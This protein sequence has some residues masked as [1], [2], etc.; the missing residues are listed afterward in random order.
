M[1]ILHDGGQPYASTVFDDAWVEA[2]VGVSPDTLAARV[3][4]FG[5]GA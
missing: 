5:E 3:A 2:E 4:A 1:L